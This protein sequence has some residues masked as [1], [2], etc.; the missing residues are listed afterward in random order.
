M[1]FWLKFLLEN[2]CSHKRWLFAIGINS[3]LNWLLAPAFI[4]QHYLVAFA[5]NFLSLNKYFSTL[6]PSSIQK[7]VHFKE[8]ANDN[9]VA[10]RRTSPSGRIPPPVA[11]RPNGRAPTTNG[12]NTELDTDPP[13]VPPRRIRNEFLEP[14]PQQACNGLPP[15]PKVTVGFNSNTHF[16]F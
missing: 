1:K 10:G 3:A 12:E 9:A 6:K 16:I 8:S 11:P 15:T 7:A 14:Q 2:N 4:K 13:V 5:L